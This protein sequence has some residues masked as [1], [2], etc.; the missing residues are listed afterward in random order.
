[1]PLASRQIARKRELPTS[2]WG[3]EAD[4]E[5]GVVAQLLCLNSTVL[6]AVNGAGYVS[7]SPPEG[8]SL[9]APRNRTFSCTKHSSY[10]RTG[11]SVFNNTVLPRTFDN[12]KCAM[13]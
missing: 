9:M 6:C 2:T 1:M 11:D 7:G 12:F 10:Y 4:Y 3:L 8:L 13:S 5:D